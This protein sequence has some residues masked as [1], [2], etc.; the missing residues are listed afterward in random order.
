MDLNIILRA[1]ITAKWLL[2]FLLYEV[3][4]LA[5]SGG[6]RIAPLRADHA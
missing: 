1:T 2:L 5:L 4:R 6:V 3:A